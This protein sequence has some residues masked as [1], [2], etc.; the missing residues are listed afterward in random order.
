MALRVVTRPVAWCAVVES[1]WAVRV[2]E[3]LARTASSDP[4]PGGGSIAAVSGALG[5]GLMQMAL[6]V[7]GDVAL[8]GCASRLGSLRD[9]IVAA[10]DGD[11]QDFEAVLSAL[12]LPR[13]DEAQRESRTWE[14]ERTSV[15]ATLRPLNLAEALLEA[16]AVSREAEPLVKPS[17][18]SD[19]L[20]G[21]DIVHGAA[22]AAVR[23][24]DINIRQLERVSSSAA[25]GLRAR[26]NALVAAIEEAL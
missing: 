8:E 14:V 9:G 19:V 2:D 10:A 23:T 22:R 1:L 6:A 11:V 7:T 16:V 4:V 13:D 17:I 5:V 26:R 18:V 12:Q 21:R 20:E 25:P 24:A 15:A 3:L